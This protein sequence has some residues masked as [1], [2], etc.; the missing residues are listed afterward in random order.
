MF[1]NVIWMFGNSFLT[2]VRYP[3]PYISPIL[4]SDFH[5][6]PENGLKTRFLA[7]FGAKWPKIR[8]FRPFSGSLWKSE[9]MMGDI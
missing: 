5:K 6:L 9:E 7:I 8:V 1:S 4:S 2:F 3:Y